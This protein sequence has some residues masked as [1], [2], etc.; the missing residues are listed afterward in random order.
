MTLSL[1]GIDISHSRLV[2]LAK[3]ADQAKPF[4]DWVEAKARRLLKSSSTLDEILKH[5]TQKDLTILLT[6]CYGA[7]AEANVPILTDG[8]GRSYPHSKACYYFF[9]WI[10]RDAPQ[11]RLAPLVTRVA[12]ASGE[13]RKDV[14]VQVLTA[15]ILQYRENV[16][17][18]RWEAV[19]EVILDRLEGSRRSIK[20]HEKETIVRT[21][22]VAAFQ[23][24]YEK[25]GNYGVFAGIEI[26]ETQ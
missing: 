16:K 3:L 15:L 21:A 24:F 11:Q 14:E 7:S 9:A 1:R 2:D 25:H 6:A 26:P 5:A 18:F 13:N 8:V 10:V 22:L 4:Y 17:N 12:G 19:R 23:A 20:G